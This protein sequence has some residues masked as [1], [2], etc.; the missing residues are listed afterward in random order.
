MIAFTVSSLAGADPQSKKAPA[1]TPAPITVPADA[2]QVSP[3]LYRSVDKQ[4]KAWLY[5]RTPFGVRRWEDTAGDGK[6]NTAA[7]RTTAV[8]QGDSIRFE[9]NT[10]F[11]KQ[12][13]VRKKSELDPTE[14]QIWDHQQEKNTAAGKAAKE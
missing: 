6:Q 1:P 12:T 2:V 3:G 4:G 14:Q 11:G 7:D 10:P 9:R 5:R 8:E 13:W